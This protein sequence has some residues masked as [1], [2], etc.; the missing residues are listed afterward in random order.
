MKTLKTYEDLEFET[1]P[2]GQ[3]NLAKMN[4]D[5]GYGVSVLLG[6]MFYSNGTTTYEVA[7]TKDGVL[8]YDTHITSDV[9]GYVTYDTVTEIMADV[10]MLKGD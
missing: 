2:I 10:Q 6:N 4:F 9:I 5:N 1:H 8:C 3:G 7:V